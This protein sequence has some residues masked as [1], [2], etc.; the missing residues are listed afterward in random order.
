[1]KSF[2]GSMALVS[3]FS[4]GAVMTAI[5]CSST[6]PDERPDASDAQ[7][8]ADAGADADADADASTAKIAFPEPLTAIEIQSGGGMPHGCFDAGVPVVN[9][10]T[11][12]LRLDTKV[13][14]RTYQRACEAKVDHDEVHLTEA[15]LT[16][17]VAR[18]RSLP[19]VKP[20][21]S[22]MVD[23]ESMAVRGFAGEKAG[24]R[25]FTADSESV[26]RLEA[27]LDTAAT[28]ALYTDLLAVD[29]DASAP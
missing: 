19:L 28:R 6:P 11:L 1:M 10:T 26:C 17:F 7:A 22:C 23:G 3:F 18:A 2:L 25:F 9:M 4:V 14:D 12:V 8:D 21:A 16:A 29:R 27:V 20:G 5:A 24:T 15:Q 13:L